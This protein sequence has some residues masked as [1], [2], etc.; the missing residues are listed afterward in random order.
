MRDVCEVHDQ[1]RTFMIKKRIQC[2]LGI[3]A[4]I[5]H[6]PDR[7]SHEQGTVH[8]FRYQRQ[9]DRDD[10]RKQGQRR[11]VSRGYIGR[12]KTPGSDRQNQED[13]DNTQSRRADKDHPLPS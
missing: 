8:L 7:D 5:E 2:R 9:R 1:S 12:R 4:C 6:R 3:A 13:S 10:R 11:S